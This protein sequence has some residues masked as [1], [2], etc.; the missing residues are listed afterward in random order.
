MALVGRSV[1]T[2]P[3][4]RH[5]LEWKDNIKTEPQAVRL[6]GTDLNAVA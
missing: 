1:G 2:R 5:R 3:L 4:G 6:G